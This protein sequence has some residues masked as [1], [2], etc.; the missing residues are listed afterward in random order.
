[1]IKKSPLYTSLEQ[2]LLFSLLIKE[3]V[4]THYLLNSERTWY[5]PFQKWITRYIYAVF[6]GNSPYHSG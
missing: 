1:M 4:K 6:L 5:F 3:V 2:L